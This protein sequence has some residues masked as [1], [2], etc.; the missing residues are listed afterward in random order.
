M[1]WLQKLVFGSKSVSLDL[2]VQKV[3]DHASGVVDE[4]K[5]HKSAMAAVI[6]HAGQEVHAAEKVIADLGAF[7]R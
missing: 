4:A 7:R 6:A 3:Y 5:T 2:K 1:N